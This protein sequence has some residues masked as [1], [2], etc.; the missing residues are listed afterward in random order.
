MAVGG[1]RWP[2]VAVGGRRWPSVGFIVWCELG[3]KVRSQIAVRFM[4]FHEKIRI[5][6]LETPFSSEQIMS[7]IYKSAW[8]FES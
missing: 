1:R 2:S 6:L 5:A 8:S 7:T 4:E 3:F